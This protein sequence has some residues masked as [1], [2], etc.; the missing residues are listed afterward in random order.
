MEYKNQPTDYLEKEYQRLLYMNVSW[1]SDDIVQ[2]VAYN[3][4]LIWA[5]LYYRQQE[6]NKLI[7]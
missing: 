2:T 5:I 1:L 4:D 7:K 6:N 3:L